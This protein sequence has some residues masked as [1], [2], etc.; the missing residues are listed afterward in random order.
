MDISEILDHFLLLED[1]KELIAVLESVVN[2]F[3]VEVD[4][5]DVLRLILAIDMQVL[6]FR[7]LLL[8]S[9]LKVMFQNIIV[10]LRI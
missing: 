9:I 3:N 2:R 10:V 1:T 4:G 8:L 5:E 6:F 7:V